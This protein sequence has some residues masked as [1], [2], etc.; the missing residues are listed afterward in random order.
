MRGGWRILAAVFLAA[1][2]ILAGGTAQAGK[3]KV[4]HSFCG[5]GQHHSC[6]DGSNPQSGLVM[7]AAGNFYGTTANGG[8]DFGTAFELER[9]SGGGFNFKTIFRFC[10]FCGQSPNGTLIIDTQGNLYGTAK[11]LVFELSPVIGQKRWAEKIV[12]QFCSQQNCTDGN[13]PLGGLTYAGASSGAPYDGV[14]P[15]YG[16]TGGGGTN[17]A[18]TIFELTNNT[19]Q[20]S[21][22]VLYSFCSQGG[23]QCTDGKLPV[24]ALLMDA[25]GDLFGTTLEGGGKQQAGVAFDLSPSGQNWSYTLLYTFCSATNCTDGS[26]PGA[27]LVFDSHGGDLLGTTSGG[28]AKCRRAGV[29]GCGTVFQ[30]TLVS[31]TWQEMVLHSFCQERDCKDGAG[32]AGLLIDGAGNIFGTTGTGGGHDTSSAPLGGG[33]IFEL[34]N[35]LFSVLH[36]FCSAANCADGQGPEAGLVADRNGS[37]FGTTTYGGAYANSEFGGTVFRAEP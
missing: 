11:N 29:T 2:A 9:K 26:N 15:L 16:V 17:N 37:L 31:G 27:P 1:G 19:G 4:L 21:E 8:R 23:D 18:G 25:S 5:S 30:L 13:G 22:A 12:Y 28:G 36:R 3:F 20:W 6:N 35:S 7:D 33:I 34:S 32:P 10:T 14:S 24:S